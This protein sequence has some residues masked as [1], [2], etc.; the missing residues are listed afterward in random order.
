MATAGLTG[1]VQLWDVRKIPT[2]SS[3]EKPKPLSWQE[4]GRSINSAFFSPSG[5]RL[6]TTT[7]SNKLDILEDAHLAKG[8]I[9]EPK[10][11]V[12]HDNQTGRWLSTFMARW[13]PSSSSSNQEIF[14]VGSM[15]QPRCIEVFDHDGELL[16]EIRGDALTAVASRCCFH[17]DPNRLIVVGGNSSGRVTIAR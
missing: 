12:R 16:R 5:R 8:L 10:S 7:Q 2:M 6:L 17:P 13:H 4:A 1:V 3:R 9:G 14:V 11:S 15:R